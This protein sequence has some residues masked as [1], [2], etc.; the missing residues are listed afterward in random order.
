MQASPGF[1]AMD[2]ATR[3]LYRNA[4]EELGR[5]SPLS[6]L[7]IAR[8]ALALAARA[9]KPREQDPGYYLIADGRRALER[10]ISFRARL[11]DLPSR[12]SFTVG[13]ADYVA[14]IAFTIDL[15]SLVLADCS[16]PTADGLTAATVVPDAVTVPTVTA[17]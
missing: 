17:S 11:R 16:N 14:A 1:E 5:G 3:N 13:A 6:E 8:H 15:P 12:I 9:T 4:I 7:E 10:A 2:F